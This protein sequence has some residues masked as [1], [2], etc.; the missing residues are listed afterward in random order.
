MAF[1]ILCASVFVAFKINNLFMKRTVVAYSDQL[2]P[3]F[4]FYSL[5]TVSF[6]RENLRKGEDIIVIHFDPEC[7][8]C[9]EE[10]DLIVKNREAFRSTEIVM[11]SEN[12]PDKI[13]NFS[14]SFQLDKYESI[15]VLWD[16]DRQ[17]S[18]LF[19]G[20]TIPTTFIYNRE[21]KL[22]KT[23]HGLAKLE[24]LTKWLK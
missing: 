22:L 20:S 11:V 21:R 15:H 8:Y 17:F 18:Y 10:A 14:K 19:G 7:N 2:I 9:T 4:N 3:D 16:K 5:D 13:R 23:Y 6:S 24:A 1:V 12:T